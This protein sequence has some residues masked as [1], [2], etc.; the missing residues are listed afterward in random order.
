[1]QFFGGTMFR[2]FNQRERQQWV[3]DST[4]SLRDYQLSNCHSNNGWCDFQIFVMAILSYVV[5]CVNENSRQQ[6][7]CEKEATAVPG[8]TKLTFQ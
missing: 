6:Y 1:M 3:V 7:R 2:Q 5:R 4:P 8:I